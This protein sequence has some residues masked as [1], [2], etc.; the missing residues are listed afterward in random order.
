MLPFSPNWESPVTERLEWLTDLIEAYD[1]T[2]EATPLR[3]QPRRSFEYEVLVQ[4][5]EAANLD[6]LLWRYQAEKYVVPI[7]TDP[8][9]LEA[10]LPA[11][12][13]TITVPTVDYDFSA[14][15]WAVLWTSTTEYELV[16]VSGTD[17]SSLTLNGTVQND[18]PAGTR[19]YPAREG[20]H[21]RC[22]DAALSDRGHRHP[23]AA[24][25][26]RSEPHHRG[27]RRDHL[28]R[29]RGGH[30]GAQLGSGAPGRPHPQGQGI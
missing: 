12:T 19:I 1:G 9:F 25:E 17:A 2:E 4:A 8:Q 26:S 11:G 14:P 13:G 28:P 6:A 20:A 15:G 21:S 23:H 10:A 3:T 29:H 30:L 5:E 27:A 18:W 16:E 24:Y 7:W 22:R